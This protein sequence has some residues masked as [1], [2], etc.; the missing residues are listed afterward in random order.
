MGVAVTGWIAL[1]L[2]E[3]AEVIRTVGK[4]AIRA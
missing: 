2:A 3:H 4:R 1:R